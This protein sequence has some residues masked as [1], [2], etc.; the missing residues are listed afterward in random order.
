MVA[1][2]PLPAT[3]SDLTIFSSDALDPVF[4]TKKP[5]CSFAIIPLLSLCWKHQTSSE[6]LFDF[7]PLFLTKF[8]VTPNKKSQFSKYSG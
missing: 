1:V 5:I 2:P 8:G 3:G 7:A 6:E 4:P